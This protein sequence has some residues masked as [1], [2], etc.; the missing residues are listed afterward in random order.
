MPRRA[1]KAPA[2]RGRLWRPIAGGAA[3]AAFWCLFLTTSAR[4]ATAGA[5]EVQVEHAR[6]FDA[7]CSLLRRY[8][9][10][11]AWRADLE[12]RL[13]AM[14]ALWA[15]E[16]RPIL[17]RAFELSGRRLHG[18]RTVRATLC[19]L[20]S[21]SLLGT[22]VNM[23]H[24]L[25]SF[26]QRPVPLRYKIAIIDHELLHELLED[27]K[28]EDG[29]ML[30]LHAAEPPRVRSHLHLFA[31]LKAAMLDVGEGT[32]LLE[33]QRIDAGLPEPAYGRAWQLV[34]RSPYEYLAYVEEIKRAQ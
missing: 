15:S 22:S 19:D 3:A 32:A 25:P 4:T 33:M 5:L 26:T 29:G 30:A 20:P 16:G 24:A 18:H 14:R 27:V 28:L 8:K 1:T 11:A 6:A 13:P 2:V 31:L 10:E 17:E 21:S 23:R 9:V 7:A 34:N 12:A